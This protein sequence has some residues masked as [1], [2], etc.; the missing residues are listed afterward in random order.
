MNSMRVL[1]AW[2]KLNLATFASVPKSK[3]SLEFCDIIVLS[4]LRNKLP[5]SS[6][7]KM[8]NSG[9]QQTFWRLQRIWSSMNFYLCCI[10]IGKSW[11]LRWNL[12]TKVKLQLVIFFLIFCFTLFL[13]F[14]LSSMNIFS[15]FFIS[16]NVFFNQ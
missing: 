14:F 9:T 2:Q 11:D 3:K 15:S 16:V 8:K 7:V 13:E 4:D 1:K 10:K 5:L 12:F 6:E